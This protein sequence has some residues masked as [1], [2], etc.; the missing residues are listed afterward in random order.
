MHK[1]VKMDSN[2]INFLNQHYSQEAISS[3]KLLTG[4]GSERKYYR[5]FNN[6]QSYILCHS[7]NIE[8]N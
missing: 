6:N 2:I 1:I 7:S 4:G 8:E 3:L 5:F